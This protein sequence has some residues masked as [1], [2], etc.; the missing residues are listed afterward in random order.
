[1][2]TDVTTIETPRIQL[3]A[4][5]FGTFQLDPDDTY[6]CVTAALEVGYR[7]IDTAQMYR[8]EEAVGRAIDDSPVDRDEVFLTTKVP[9][10]AAAPTDVER[11]HKESLQRLGVDHVDLLL[12]HW[13]SE[14]VAPL[15]ATLEAFTDL[16]EREMT[17]HIGVSNFPSAMLQRA[18]D[19]ALIV[20]DQVEHHPYLAVDRIIEVLDANDGFLT[21]YCPLAQGAVLDDPVL[22]DIGQAHGVGPVQVTVR[23][24]L[25]RG[26]SAIP[27]TSKPERVASNAD[28]FGFEL[29]ADEMARIDGLRRGQRLIDPASLQV[30]W[31]ED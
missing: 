23:W 15:E 30:P 31:D 13:P 2:T 24:L 11:T 26:I 1:M 19:L 25:Q 16:R 22:V 12:L 7:H 20:T 8:N 17:R 4:L 29:D 18:F 28:V 10:D 3:P 14:H 6:R 9:P 27:R 5:G 21:A